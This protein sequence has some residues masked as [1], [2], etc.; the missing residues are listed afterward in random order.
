MT[1]QNENVRQLVWDLQYI[2]TAIEGSELYCYNIE[3]DT[4]SVVGQV[5][6]RMYETHIYKF[7]KEEEEEVTR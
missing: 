6:Y 7:I 4:N 1:L 3:G 2:D 5:S